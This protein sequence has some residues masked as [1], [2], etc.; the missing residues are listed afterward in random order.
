MKQYLY[1]LKSGDFSKS[2][3]IWT[4]NP[5][6]L[7]SNSQYKNY[8]YTR[9]AYGLDLIGDRTYVGVEV[10]SPSYT[11]YHATPLNSNARYVTDQGEVISELA[12][13]GLLRFIDTNS[14]VDV[15]TYRHTF[16]NIQGTAA[17]GFSLLVYESDTS[18]GP[19]L[20]ST[21]TN[22][23]SAI[24]IQ[25]S[26]PY[27][28]LELE[29]DDKGVDLNQVGLIFYLEILIY[30]PVSPVITSSAKAIAKKFPTWTT[31]FEDSLPAATPSLA[32]PNS[33]GGKFLTALVQDGLDKF[34]AEVDVNDI[35]SFI[36]SVNEEMVAWAYITA[37]VPQNL[38]E[39]YG[40]SIQLARIGTLNDL[41][42]GKSTDYTFYYNPKDKTFFTLRKFS[43]LVIN[44]V[45][46]DQEAI[47]IFNQFDEFGAR[48]SLP[49]LYL[50]S[51]SNYKKR[52]LDVTQNLP[53]SSLEAFKR[54]LRREL[55]IWRAYGSTPDSEY[56]GA[57]PEVFEI[58][59]LENTTPYFTDSGQPNNLF[60]KLVEDLNTRYPTNIGYV[61]WEEGIWDYAGLSGEG[62]SRLPAIYDDDS[63]L[64]G[65]IFQPGVGDFDDAKIDLYKLEAST[66]DFH[67]GIKI[68][69]LKEIGS[70]D[71]YPPVIVDYNWFASYLVT[72]PDIDGNRSRVA[73]VYEVSLRN[74][75]NYATPSTFY[76]NLN[77]N[78]RTDFRP[79]NSLGINSLSSPEYSLIPIFDSNGISLSEIEFRDKVYN[80]RYF[81][82]TRSASNNIDI[83]DAASINIVY[84]QYWSS[85]AYTSLT[86]DAYKAGFSNA[87]TPNWRSNPSAGTTLTAASPNINPYNSSIVIASNQYKSKVTREYTDIY[88]GSAVINAPSDYITGIDSGKIYS[89]NLIQSAVPRHVKANLDYI[90][91]QA[92]TPGN[93]PLYGSEYSTSLPGGKSFNP[94]D[95][96][97]YLVPS[98]PNILMYPFNS[99]GIATSTPR[100]F[101]AATIS[102]SATPTYI[103]LVTATPSS[104][105]IS[106]TPGGRYYPFIKTNYE[107]FEAETDSNLYSGFIDEVDRVFKNE[108]EYK[109]S[110][111]LKDEFLESVNLDRLSFNLE[112]TPKYIVDSLEFL[113]TPNSIDVY[114]IDKDIVIQNLNSAFSVDAATVNYTNT[115]FGDAIVYIDVTEETGVFDPQIIRNLGSGGSAFDAVCGSSKYPGTAYI[116]NKELVL[117]GIDSNY[118]SIP[119]NA[120]L[121]ITGTIEILVRLNPSA[122]WASNGIL[123]KSGAYRL[124]LGP[125]PTTLSFGIWNGSSWNSV[126]SNSI[127]KIDTPMWVKVVRVQGTGLIY[128]YWAPDQDQIPSVWINGGSSTIASPASMPTSANVLEIGSRDTG[129]GVFNGKIERAII[130]NGLDGPIVVD[131]DFTKLPDWCNS[132]NEASSNSLL[133]AVNTTNSAT[134][135]PRILPVQKA[136]YIY[137]PSS[138]INNITISDPSQLAGATQLD[139]RLVAALDDWTP[140]AVTVLTSQGG[141]TGA[142]H[143]FGFYLRDNGGLYIRFGDGTNLSS[144]YGNG[145]ITPADNTLIAVRFTWRSS[146][147]RIQF[148]TKSTSLETIDS[149]IASNVGWVQLGTDV[150][151]PLVG[152]INSTSPLGVGSYS[153]GSVPSPGKYYAYQIATTIN[154]APFF[155]IKNSDIKPLAMASDNTFS[156]WESRLMSS[157]G[158][159]VT[160]NKSTSGRRSVVMP[161]I[162]DNG[163]S[164]LLFGVDDY[165]EI[166]GNPY[167]A[168]VR[169][170]NSTST[171][172][173]SPHDQSAN[174]AG[175][176]EIIS[177]LAL[178]DWKVSGQVLFGK[179]YGAAYYAYIDSINIVL[180]VRIS[181]AGSSTAYSVSWPASRRPSNG[182]P[183]WLRVTRVQSTGLIT[184]FMSTDSIDIPT[185]W[186]TIGSTTGT[187]SALETSFT[188]P[189]VFG[190]A[191]NSISTADTSTS[192]KFYRCQLKSGASIIHDFNAAGFAK[193][194]NIYSDI[195]GKTWNLVGSTNLVNSNPINFGFD[196]N[197]TVMVI[198]RCQTFGAGVTRA[199]LSK[200]FHNTASPGWGLFTSTTA[201]RVYFNTGSSTPSGNYSSVN[202]SSTVINARGAFATSYVG[203]RNSSEHNF[204]TYDETGILNTASTTSRQLNTSNDVG[205]RVGQTPSGG[206]LWE[207]ELL[208]LA[209]WDRVL[210]LDEIQ[211]A[212]K[213]VFN[214]T[215]RGMSK[216]ELSSIDIGIYAKKDEI[217]TSA[218]AL[219]ISS[220]WIHPSQ[221]NEQYI[222][223]DPESATYNGRFYELEIPYAQRS[224]AP[225][226]V[227]VN[228]TDVRN[229][230][231]ED[232]ATPG[233]ASF[234]NTE[235]AKGTFNNSLYLA[236]Q[237]VSNI[238]VKDTYTGKTLFTNL[239]TPG[240]SINP[241]SPSTPCILNR[242]YEL[243]YYV[244]NAFYVDNDVYDQT[245]D[246][247]KSKIY[248]SSTP[249]ATANYYVT[250]EKSY[251]KNYIDSELSIS[252]TDSPVSEGFIYIDSNEYSFDYIETYLSPGYITDSTDDLMYLSIIS[253]DING[254]FKPYQ[255]FR[256]FGDS[257]TAEDEF[258]TTN[259]NGFARTIIRYSGPIPAVSKNGSIQVVGIGAATPDS[260]TS[261]ETEYY[262]KVIPYEIV[263]TTP[264]DLKVKATPAKLHYNADGQTIVTVYGQIYWKDK[265]FKKSINLGWNK[266]RTLYDLFTNSLSNSLVSNP[267]GSF[268]IS[269]VITTQSRLDPGHWFLRVEITDSTSVI[270]NLLQQVGEVISAAD[271]TISGD[272]IYWNEKYD[273]LNYANEDLPLSNSFTFVR[274]NGSE[275][276]STPNFVYRHH[277]GIELVKNNSTTTWTLPKWVSLRKF[278]QYQMGLFGTTP[279]YISTYSS[280]HPDSGEE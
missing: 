89:K 81:N 182:V 167:D 211:E 68:S 109:N 13:P 97:E 127:L 54:T 279:N 41:L 266:R 135:D 99:N 67:G 150:V 116:L 245:T 236:Y 280:I 151:G 208:S 106:S 205:V 38:V 212:S 71:I 168:Y 190:G 241:F 12:T 88:S 53:G 70:V 55:D 42:D 96:T 75:D 258:I 98:S 108:I 52:I 19:W 5:I 101:D 239:S 46:Y 66:I 133:A 137:V 240:N 197:F 3:N 230:V 226:S 20:R 157:T 243:V 180:S 94:I 79:T 139:C 175:D 234:Y 274:Q 162:Q 1:L 21:I 78:T 117:P 260:S 30:D 194:A 119:S 45:K 251:K 269:N 255:S 163:K 115:P 121:N 26:K 131:A 261:S 200:H 247:Y 264:Y 120:V 271:I 149:D 278:D 58:S 170:N 2:G 270:Q 246:S 15:L 23:S 77:Y 192:G 221:D 27:I 222:Y 223:V 35:N 165:L 219:G 229:I 84:G 44:N 16:T 220:G 80:Q 235:I 111:L 272:I 14:R 155:A 60:K 267:D 34:L 268:E 172:I 178:D 8:S 233:K 238:S 74:H 275:L 6:N 273:N 122:L 215:L 193:G 48:V 160:V 82:S 158:Q 253:Y 231:F 17:P 37:N 28:K 177:K 232:A 153:D 63:Q 196:D 176:F 50:E 51:N 164:I 244:N 65:D 124:I 76:A 123:T 129:I 112:A 92:A 36:N 184:W 201:P 114:T 206:F 11:G 102:Y 224:G 64:I 187:T 85:G 110:F 227:R 276:I 265:P 145:I 140:S 214:R 95:E 183:I 138:T 90:I 148:F 40:D 262:E 154:G 22:D 130:R 105:I 257:I 144:Y 93:L 4:S 147:G 277:N 189:F 49:R 56:L 166:S 217:R 141:A 61:R 9:S 250:Y 107:Y 132:F 143:S 103:G 179:T 32:T 152:L 252:Q 159:I 29:I 156:K 209:V 134:N 136:G 72:G 39:I 263:R 210:S 18:S 198:N 142:A 57:T 188:G 87:P 207:G 228:N 31:I 171:L 216:D 181:G 254:N 24:F 118:V 199:M 213:Y 125:D 161:K 100:F 47:N 59:D 128:F 91:L 7:Y 169:K 43:N 242:E 259:Q 203:R 173:Y 248:F 249:S 10:S 237:D 62:V 174:I 113:T 204:Y 104:G 33:V 146:D 256:I 69:G 86:T 126:A 25:N 225:V 191:S 218:Y 186:T 185:S 73:L 195:R 202:T 83:N